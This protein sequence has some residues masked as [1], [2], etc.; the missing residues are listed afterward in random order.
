M[1]NVT[2]LTAA[3]SVILMLYHK[4]KQ[5]DD[6]QVEQPVTAPRP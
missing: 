2:L 5:W 3:G 6:A 1:L 4:V